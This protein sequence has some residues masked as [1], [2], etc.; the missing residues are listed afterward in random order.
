[1]GTRTIGDAKSLHRLQLWAVSGEP[2]ARR[3][4]PE[5]MVRKAKCGPDSLQFPSSFQEPPNQ[6][7]FRYMLY[8]TQMCIGCL[9]LT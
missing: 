8:G 2:R 4:S 1:M 3:A 6:V 9:E 7:Y 5:Q